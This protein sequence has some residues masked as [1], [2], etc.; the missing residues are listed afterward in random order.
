M[1]GL[2]VWNVHQATI[3]AC[4]HRMN[5]AKVRRRCRSFATTTAGLLD[6]LAC[7]P[8]RRC[9]HVAMEATGV[10][11]KSVWNTSCDGHFVL[12]V[13][14]AAYINNVLG[15]K[16]D[17]NDAMWI[18]DLVAC[19][20]LREGFVPVESPQELRSLMHTRK[21]VS[22]E[23]TGMCSVTRAPASASLC[24]AP[25]VAL[26]ED[27]ARPVR[28]GGQAQEGQIRSRPVPIIRRPLTPVTSQITVLTLMLAASH[29]IDCR[30]ERGGDGAD[31]LL[32]P[33]EPMAQNR[34]RAPR[35]RRQP[36]RSLPSPR[37]GST[38][39]RSPRQAR[40]PSPAPTP[41]PGC[42]MSEF[43]IC[44]AKQ[45]RAAERSFG[46]DCF[47]GARRNDIAPICCNRLDPFGVS[48]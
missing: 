41:S 39:G 37:S 28:L 26:A 2:P 24:A 31:C 33:A 11:W 21:Q 14:N 35:P 47:V 5:G 23:E 6:L 7:L 1:R 25:R 22:R 18:A 46:L 13:A 20:P 45:F 38:A 43:L 19:G 30:Q 17:M 32:P 16:T 12:I 48:V 29:V 3:V 34:H 15:G 8:A 10:Y 40:L 4:V 44:E 27:H 42:P 9:N 36:L